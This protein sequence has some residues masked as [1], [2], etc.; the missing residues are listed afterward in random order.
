M[1]P[2]TKFAGIALPE[3]VKAYDN[4]GNT[5]MLELPGREAII[6]GRLRCVYT[7]RNLTADRGL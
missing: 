6:K 5:H 2:G 4:A 3:T 1:A 7:D